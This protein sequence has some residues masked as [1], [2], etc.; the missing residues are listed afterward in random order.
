MAVLCFSKIIFYQQAYQSRYDF[1][2][3]VPCRCYGFNIM[4][5]NL[6]LS[7]YPDILDTQKNTVSIVWYVFSVFHLA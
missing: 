5:P 6:L 7:N 1:W 2:P 3:L 4:E